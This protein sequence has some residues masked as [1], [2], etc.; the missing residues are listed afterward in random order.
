MGNIKER[1]HLYGIPSMVLITIAIVKLNLV[2]VFGTI[3]LYLDKAPMSMENT[4]IDW[5]KIFIL[6]MLDMVVGVVYVWIK[7]INESIQEKDVNDGGSV[8][9]IQ[10]EE[11]NIDTHLLDEG[12]KR[13]FN[14]IWMSGVSNILITIIWSLVVVT[15][16]ILFK[17]VMIIHPNTAVTLSMVMGGLKLL[18]TAIIKRGVLVYTVFST[19]TEGNILRA[20]K[21]SLVKVFRLIAIDII[22]Y[23]WVVIGMLL[24]GI[25]IFI[26]VPQALHNQ[27][28][29]WSGLMRDFERENMY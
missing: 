11:D 9:N 7:S 6:L 22:Y 13:G 8:K 14:Y 29:R 23:M 19:Y 5:R 1:I 28:E 12:L 20:L 4:V 18:I 2:G 17:S 21:F 15:L 10:G 3:Y 27:T 26:T 24:V 25:G 16:S